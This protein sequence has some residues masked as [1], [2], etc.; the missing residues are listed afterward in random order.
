MI[1]PLTNP[2]RT[3]ILEQN[4]EFDLVGDSALLEKYLDQ[5]ILVVTKDGK[6]YRGQLLSGRSDLVL[7][8]SGGEVT[9]VKLD[10]VQEFSFPELPQGLITK[11]T[12]M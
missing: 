6:E 9:V 5:Q 2:G 11:P 8:E 3:S 12:L 4:F 7:Q 10:N 1:R